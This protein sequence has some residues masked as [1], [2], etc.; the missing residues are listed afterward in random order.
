MCQGGGTQTPRHSSQYVDMTDNKWYREKRAKPSHFLHAEIGRCEVL[1]DDDG[2]AGTLILTLATYMLI[3]TSTL[4]P[5]AV[6]LN[7]NMICTIYTWIM[8]QSLH[9]LYTL[10]NT[11]PTSCIAARCARHLTSANLSYEELMELLACGPTI[12]ETSSGYDVVLHHDVRRIRDFLLVF[13]VNKRQPRMKRASNVED[14][15]GKGQMQPGLVYIV[16]QDNRVILRATTEMRITAENVN[17][18][19]KQQVR[20]RSA[21]D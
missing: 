5:D 21:R 10:A 15:E 6:R 4:L 20:S 12:T 16:E 14:V 13:S 19:I 1:K 9:D 17:N 18:C 11:N 2:D 7:R 3:C 8:H